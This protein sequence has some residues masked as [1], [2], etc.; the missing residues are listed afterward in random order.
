MLAIIF[1]GKKKKA[2]FLFCVTVEHVPDLLK[3]VGFVLWFD[4]FV[5][6]EDAKYSWSLLLTNVVRN[7]L[8]TVFEVLIKADA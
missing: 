3:R 5:A 8:V 2:S 6:L 1:E 7:F 4:I